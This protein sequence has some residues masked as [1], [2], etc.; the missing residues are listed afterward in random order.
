LQARREVGRLTECQLLLPG[1]APHLPHDDQASMDAQACRQVHAA[2][3][4]Q[5]GIELPQ[6]VDHA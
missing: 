1:T 5:A 6:R 2:F 3:L 4:H